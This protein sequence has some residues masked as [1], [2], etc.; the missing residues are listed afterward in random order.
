[1]PHSQIVD[2]LG[3]IL[4]DLDQTYCIGSLLAYIIM[5]N[6]EQGLEMY[7]SYYLM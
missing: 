4:I 2:T 1:M 7:I 6:D 5:L 3:H